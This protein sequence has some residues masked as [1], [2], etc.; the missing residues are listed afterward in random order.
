MPS[1]RIFLRSLLGTSAGVALPTI[2]RAQASYSLRPAK[3]PPVEV[4][5][6]FR[7]AWIRDVLRGHAQFVTG[8]QSPLRGV[9]SRAWNAGRAARSGVVSNYTSYEPERA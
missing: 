3:S 4:P 6:D 8:Q 1:R 5:E 2:A 9:G 7:R